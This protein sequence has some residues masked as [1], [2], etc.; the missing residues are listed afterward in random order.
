MWLIET[1][2]RAGGL[3]RYPTKIVGK[4]LKANSDNHYQAKGAMSS[5]LNN[6]QRLKKVQTFGKSSGDDG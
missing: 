4:L 2:R 1:R 6:V 5:G 3:A